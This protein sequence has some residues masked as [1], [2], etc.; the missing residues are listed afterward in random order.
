MFG[1]CY[2]VKLIVIRVLGE[3]VFVIVF[4]N[5]FMFDEMIIEEKF[6]GSGRISYLYIWV[7][8]YGNNKCKC[9]VGGVCLEC[10]EE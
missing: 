2:G 9:F 8:K 5:L 7:K 10:K 4:Y 6:K 1:K 3:G